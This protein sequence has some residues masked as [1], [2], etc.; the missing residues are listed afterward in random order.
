MTFTLHQ[1]L[2]Y[3]VKGKI[4]TVCGEEEFM[5]SHLNSVKYVEMDGEFIETPCQAFE[6]VSPMVAGAKATPDFPKAVKDVPRMASLKDARDVVEDKSCTIWGQHPNIPFKSDKIG[7]GFTA[8]AQ[9]EVIRAHIGKPPFHINNHEVNALED[10]ENECDFDHW[11]YLT[12]G[13]GLN[14]WCA[15]DFIPPPSIR[16]NYHLIFY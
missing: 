8:K 7:L 13:E 1:K 10:S 14:N 11:I 4:I 9:K 12:V 2:K 3:L 5:V 16:S 15:K 6:V